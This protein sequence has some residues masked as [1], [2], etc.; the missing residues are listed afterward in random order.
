LAK[1]KDAKSNNHQ[2]DIYRLQFFDPNFGIK[3]RNISLAEINDTKTLATII[4]EVLNKE[5]LPSYLTKNFNAIHIKEYDMIA[6]P[7]LALK[8]D[9]KKVIIY[10][11]LDSYYKPLFINNSKAKLCI[12]YFS[13]LVL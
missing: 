6:E 12:Y 5:D 8:G 13:A 10:A 7:T 4:N 2:P 3:T 9:L 11:L 1:E